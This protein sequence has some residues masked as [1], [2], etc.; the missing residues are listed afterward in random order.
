MYLSCGYLLDEGVGLR[1][2]EAALIF[3]LFT[4]DVN[5]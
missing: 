4:I 2:E 3:A 1:T 5:L